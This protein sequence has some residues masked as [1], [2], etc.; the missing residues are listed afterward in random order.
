[1]LALLEMDTEAEVADFWVPVIRK[2]EPTTA[3]TK[4]ARTNPTAALLIYSGSFG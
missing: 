1:V 2:T 4:I 3:M